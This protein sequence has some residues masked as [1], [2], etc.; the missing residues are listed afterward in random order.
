MHGT[1]WK[2]NS[3]SYIGTDN[4]DLKYQHEHETGTII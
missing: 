3:V 4:L 1:Y 2:L